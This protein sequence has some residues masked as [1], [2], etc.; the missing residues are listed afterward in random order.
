MPSDNSIL[1]PYEPVE[2]DGWTKISLGGDNHCAAI[3][4]AVVGNYDRLNGGRPRPTADDLRAFE[5]EKVTIVR[6]TANDFN[7]GAIIGEE[8]KVFIVRGDTF[9]LLPKGKRTNG[10]QL[11][12]D[13]ILDIFPGYVFEQ[14]RNSVLAIRAHFPKLRLLTP[15]RL[16]ELPANSNTMSLCCFGTWQMP[17]GAATDAIQL[18]HEYYPEDDICETTLL[19]RPEYGFSEHGSCYGQQLLSS[20]GEVVDYQPI[21]LRES[22]ELADLDFDE[23]YSRLFDSEVSRISDSTVVE[24]ERITMSERKYRDIRAAMPQP[25]QVE[26]VSKDDYRRQKTALTRAINSGDPRAILAAV[27]KTLGQW[28]GKAWPDDWNRWRIALEDAAWKSRFDDDD[29]LS[30]ELFAAVDVLFP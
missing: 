2:K 19:L 28:S 27:E 29:G 5:Q 6:H 7:A 25:R 10:H 3:V 12:I 16:R 24:S 21:S 14:A 9:A 22:L 11:R 15:E 8:G 17:D 1:D 13:R 23:A 4:S 20:F 26:Y 30:A 18:V